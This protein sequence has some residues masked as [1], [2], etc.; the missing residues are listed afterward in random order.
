[1]NINDILNKKYEVCKNPPKEIEWEIYKTEVMEEYRELLETKG[2]SEK[3]FQL[4]F[5]KNPSFLPGALE[6]IG[7]SSHYPYM[8]ALVSQP[9]IGIVKNRKPDFLWLA[10]DSLNFAP[11]FIEIEK[12][13]KKM[14]TIKENPNSEFNQALNQIDE[15]R[16]LLDDVDNRKSFYKCF[17]VPKEMQEKTFQPQYLL[18]YGRRSEYENDNWLRNL[19]A[20]K[21]RE[22]VV[23]M[24][25]D[26]LYPL[27]DY[28]QFTSCK[29]TQGKYEIL[30]IPPT[31]RYRADSVETLVKYENFET[32][33]DSMEK[34]SE[35]RKKFL[36]E[37][38]SYW[39]EKA[40]ELSHGTMIIS[41]E[42]E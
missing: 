24:S 29:V 39:I 28:R 25:Y 19:R 2:D 13:N 14:F 40:P 12:P 20:A 6:L 33:I 30:H 22:N 41:Q 7:N 35:D 36:H 23:I 38:Y 1:M 37:R 8:D 10:Q 32:R 42:G 18:I 31:F 21:Q 34:T 11:V 15:W 16:S 27:Y 26:R 9:E 4:F 3:E 5:E 17:S